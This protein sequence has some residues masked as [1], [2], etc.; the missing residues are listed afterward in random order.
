MYTC[1]FLS[2]GIRFFFRLGP[3]SSA[4]CMAAYSLVSYLLQ[5]KERH[6][7]NIMLDTRGHIHIGEERER[8]RG[9]GKKRKRKR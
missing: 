4:A 3:T 1:S 2:L 9:R 5:I 8:E 7:G 6:N